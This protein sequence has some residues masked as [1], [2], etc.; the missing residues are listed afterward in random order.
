MPPGSHRRPQNTSAGNDLDGVSCTSVSACTAV[1]LSALNDGVPPTALAMGW[2]GSG[3][4]IQA[5]P[6][7][8]G[9]ATS[10]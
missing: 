10:A 9:S 7:P 5:V 3:W 2:D 8:A 4:H 6:T 1:G